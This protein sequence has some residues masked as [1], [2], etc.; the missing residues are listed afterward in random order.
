M[1]WVSWGAVGLGVLLVAVAVGRLQPRLRPLRRALRVLSW[2]QQEVQRL[3]ARAET[4]RG[5]LEELR[6]D[7]P[8]SFQ[9]PV[10]AYDG[11]SPTSTGE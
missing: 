9:T 7:E 6:R 10:A 5:R 3:A 1:V 2:R 11:P 8:R 4:L